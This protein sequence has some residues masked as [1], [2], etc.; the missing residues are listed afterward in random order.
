MTAASESRQIRTGTSSGA[1]SSALLTPLTSPSKTVAV[2]PTTSATTADLPHTPAP[3]LLSSILLPSE[4]KTALSLPASSI[5]VKFNLCMND[6]EAIRIL[7]VELYSSTEHCTCSGSYSS[8]FWQPST[9]YI[10]RCPVESSGSALATLAN[11]GC[12]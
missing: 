2:L 7:E 10:L 3:T 4:K 8:S 6:Y 12:M 5:E 11:S 1:L 9:T